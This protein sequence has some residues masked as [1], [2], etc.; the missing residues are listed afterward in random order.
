MKTE[1]ILAETYRIKE[2]LAD[3]AGN[4][5]HGLCARIEKS[6][7]LQKPHPREVHS[8]EE[9]AI[10]AAR[11]EPAR[12]AAIPPE[13]LETYRIH[14][15]IIAELHRVREQLC[16]ERENAPLILKDEP[17]RKP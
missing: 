5:I 7:S 14:D 10:L 2:L 15:P 3:K 13:C 1:P 6:M 16:R 12:I 17:P 4:S 11:E 9:L 8:A